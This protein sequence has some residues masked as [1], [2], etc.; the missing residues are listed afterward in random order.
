MKT[1]FKYVVPLQGI[2]Y[3]EI[4]S[5]FRVAAANMQHGVPT[6]WVVDDTEH[7]R[8]IA[9]LGIYGTG[10][11]VDEPSSFVATIFDGPFVWHIFEIH[12]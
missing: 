2:T 8:R 12:G 4:S 9:R 5:S 6:I 11:H 7:T 3:I 1:V 10:D